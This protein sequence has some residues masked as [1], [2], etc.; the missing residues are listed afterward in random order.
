MAG[1]YGR[2]WA[3]A[4]AD[5]LASSP[6]CAYCLRQGRMTVAEVVD[7]IRPHKGDEALFW[8]PANWQSLCASCHE[9]AKKHIERGGDSVIAWGADGW[10]IET[11]YPDDG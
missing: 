4:R 5:F 3:R 10:P 2:R 9:T 1:M 6:L 11:D 7:H 8:N